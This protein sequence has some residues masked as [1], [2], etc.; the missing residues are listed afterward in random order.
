MMNCTLFNEGIRLEFL[1][2]SIAHDTGDA[3]LHVDQHHIDAVVWHDPAGVE[4]NTVQHFV[5]V[6]RAAE[7][8]GA[9]AQALGQRAL[10]AFGFEK[11]GSIDRVGSNIGNRAEQT[12][13]TLSHGRPA[14]NPQRPEG[15]GLRD[16]R[17]A[18]HGCQRVQQ[19]RPDKQRL[20]LGIVGEVGA[21]S[22]DHMSD[23]ARIRRDALAGES[24]TRAT[25][26]FDDGFGGHRITH[27]QRSAVN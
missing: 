3:A 6:Q 25:S 24:L 5:E 14:A 11:I 15:S 17:H 9:I 1:I 13:V 18:G 12:H 16:E 7:G 10:I 8:R 23:D 27:D 22:L 2:A 4:E 20:V 21:A 26:Q 19:M